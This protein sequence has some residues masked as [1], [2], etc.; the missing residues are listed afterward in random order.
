MYIHNTQCTHIYTFVANN[1]LTFLS[2]NPPIGF[3]VKA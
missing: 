2:T 1:Q 3:L